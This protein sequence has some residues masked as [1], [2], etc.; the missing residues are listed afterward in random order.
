MLSPSEKIDILQNLIR[1]MEIFSQIDRNLRPLNSY[2]NIFILREA[3]KAHMIDISTYSYNEYNTSV[4]S[5]CLI[6]KQF[7]QTGY[8]SQSQMRQL[9]EIY[10]KYRKK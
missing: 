6:A 3:I 1:F 8:L 2:K 5:L 9:N 10:K 7:K 4:N